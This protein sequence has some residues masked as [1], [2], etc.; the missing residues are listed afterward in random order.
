[1]V[2]PTM[3]GA[4]TRVGG[5]AVIGSAIGGSAGV[6]ARVGAANGEQAALT[7]TA[8]R[9]VT[10]ANSRRENMIGLLYEVFPP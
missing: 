5:T 3:V 9:V 2:G 1:M 7:L 6:V 4:T 8:M 10:K